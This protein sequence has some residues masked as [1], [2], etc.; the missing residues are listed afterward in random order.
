DG[1]RDYKV[2]GVQTCALP[3]Y[4]GLTEGEFRL[5]KIP[6]HELSPAGF[7]P[8][9]DDRSSP[10]RRDAA[11]DSSD[12]TLGRA[13]TKPL[14]LAVEDDAERSEERRVGRGGRLGMGREQ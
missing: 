2:T 4:S 7:V 10:P 5:A 8:Q 14:V 13:G 1:I 6:S 11:S 12:E 3:I 9:G